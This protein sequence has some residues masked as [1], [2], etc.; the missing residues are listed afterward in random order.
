MDHVMT[1]IETTGTSP[2]H[3]GVIQISAIKF[4]LIEKTVDNQFFDRC[5]WLPSGR[6]WEEDTRAFWSKHPR[7]LQE[8]IGR[9]KSQSR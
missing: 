2:D 6:F 1:D 7:V 4:N 3:A 5:L 9:R 8:I